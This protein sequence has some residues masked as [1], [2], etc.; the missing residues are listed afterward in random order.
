MKVCGA[1]RIEKQS[2][3]TYRIRF[4]LGR[5]PLTGKYKNTP[6]RTVQGS[7]ETARR[8]LEEYRRELESGLKIDKQNTTFS[9]FAQSMMD[10]RR[11]MGNLAIATLDGD[12]YLL[13][14]LNKYLGDLLLSEIDTS[15]LKQVFIRLV[16]EDGMSQNRLHDV[17][18]KAK[19]IFREAVLADII[20]RNPAERIKT[21]KR[22]KPQRNSLTSEQLALLIRTLNDSVLDRNTVAV[23]IGVATGMRRGEVLALQWNNI[24]LDDCSITVSH[25]IDQYKRRKKP[26][27]DAGIRKISI[28]PMTVEKLREWKV[29][30]AQWLTDNGVKPTSSTYVCSN[31]RGEVCQPS[32]FYKWFKDFCVANGF[33]VYVDNEGNEIAPQKY[34]ENGFPVDAEG[35]PYTRMNKK[36]KISTHYKGLKFHEL[37]HTQATLLIANGVDI[38]TVQNRLGH[39]KAA[40]TLDFYAHA[41]EEQDR[42][43]MSVFGGLM[44]VD[45]KIA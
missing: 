4:S 14:H 1:G 32:R 11:S 23:R 7:K 6:W 45:T 37:R 21:P 16:Q 15:I 5:D 31:R 19:H 35:R 25:A 28:D 41:Q 20:I 10:E 18:V 38:K 36:P 3:D 34:N 44:G 17:V 33:G 26:K 8:A 40:M 2:K 30:Q 24:D 22:P 42:K 13:Q 39:A 27:T 9:E 12:V 29:V 43:A